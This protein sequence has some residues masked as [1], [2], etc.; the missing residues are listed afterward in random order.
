M[1]SRAE[2]AFTTDDSVATPAD[3]EG[4]AM[5]HTRWIK[6]FTGELAGSSVV[7]AIMVRI[8]NDGPAVYVGVERFEC[9]LQGRKG[10]FVLVHSA[11][12]FGGDQTGSWT[13]VPGSGG[14]ELTGI[15]GR[16]EILPNHEFVLD[17]DIDT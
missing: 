7:E 9:T 8:D 13:I 4:G 6:T 11:T 1:P 14:G 17:Y 2:S 12:A 5:S 16:G 15:R 10:T 3:W